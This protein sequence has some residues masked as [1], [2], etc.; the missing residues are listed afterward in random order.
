M[1]ADNPL[2]IEQGGGL[3][4]RLKRIRFIGVVDNHLKGLARPNMLKTTGNGNKFICDTADSLQ[5]ISERI[6]DCDRR[7]GIHKF[8]WS[9]KR[10]THFISIYKYLTAGC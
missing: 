2:W 9:Q 1:D 4:E 6:H 5:T 10:K 3:K 8:E 7:K